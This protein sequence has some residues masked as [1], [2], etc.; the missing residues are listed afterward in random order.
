MESSL[1]LSVTERLYGLSLIWQEANYNFAFFDRLPDLDWDACYQERMEEVVS[2]ED[3][4]A[5]YEL[6]QSFTALLQDGHTAII[7][8][9]SL[10]LE[11]DRPKLMMTTVGHA[12]VVT[13]ASRSIGKSVPIGSE[14]LEVDGV[15]AGDYLSGKVL[16]I[17]CESTRHR[18]LDHAISRM[19]LGRQGSRVQCKFHTPHGKTIDIELVR[20]RRSDDDPWLRPP[21]GPDRWEFMYLDEWFYNDAPFSDLDFSILEGNVAYVALN[22]FADPAVLDRFREQLATISDCSGLVIDLRKNHGGSDVIAYGI[23]AHFLREPTQTFM[24]RSLKHIASYKAFGVSLLEIPADKIPDLDETERERLLCY[25]KQWF[26]EESWGT[27]KP[28]EEALTLPVAILTDAE[29]LSAAEDFI[30]AFR[31]GKG[32][33]VIVGRSTGGS[34]GQPLVHQLPGGGIFG[35]CTVKVPWP[36]LTGRTGIEPDI[37]VEPTIEDIIRNEDRILNAAVSSLLG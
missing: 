17:V 5:Y 9:I 36:E 4:H 23:V 2:I 32:E 33:A 25:Q 15:T 7:P 28:S 10:Y 24:M 31:S 6:L 18:R 26:H 19:L 16:P 11:Q 3:P 1:Y 22:S 30:M 29:T 21:G 27:V 13:N 37:H 12:P 14:L 34:T 20:N 35:V 8:P